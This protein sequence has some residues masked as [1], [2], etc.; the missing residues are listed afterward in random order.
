M[1]E[2]TSLMLVTLPLLAYA[3]GGRDLAFIGAFAP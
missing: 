2:K 3:A 1:S